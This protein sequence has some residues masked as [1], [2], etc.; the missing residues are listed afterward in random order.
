M[1]WSDENWTN[2]CQA[3]PSFPVYAGSR[4]GFIRLCNDESKVG[5]EERTSASWRRD[6]AARF[7]AWEEIDDSSVSNWLKGN[8]LPRIGALL[9]IATSHGLSLRGLMTGDGPKH[10]ADIRSQSQVCEAPLERRL[11]A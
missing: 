4:A 6:E 5:T 10:A 1:G 9:R 8:N 7:D 3:M 11:A 2:V